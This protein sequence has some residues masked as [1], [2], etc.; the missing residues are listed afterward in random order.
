MKPLSIS[1]PVFADL[2]AAAKRIAPH[3]LQTPVLESARLNTLLGRRVLFKAEC[4]Q[5]TGAFK[6]RGA[7]NFLL[8]LDTAAK[9]RGVV[10]FSSGNHAQ[11]I[12]AAAHLFG[13][14]ATIVM[15]EDA[16]RIKIENT[17]FYGATVVLYNRVTES[18]EAIAHALAEEKGL[19]LVPPF[20]HPWTIAGQGTTGLEFAQQVADLATSLDALLIPCS[21]GGL[22]AGCALAFETLSPATQIFCVEPEGFDDTRQS[23]A[24]DKR[25]AIELPQ[26][27]TDCDALMVPQPGELTFAL[28]QR[29]L[30]GGWV[31]NDTQIHQAM[32]LLM[33]HL[34]LVVEPG[35]AIGLAALLANKSLDKRGETVGIVLSGGNVDPDLLRRVLA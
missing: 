1:L 12:A 28:N 29:L 15:P 27:H 6:Y 23:L 19:T 3:A 17:R 31:A 14:S 13:I 5:K 10:T 24:T 22:T 34:K 35:G 33:E 30:R 25:V 4:L 7:C 32:R 9:A 2:E 8:Q 20:D 26:H 18:R 16:P 11:A 21:G